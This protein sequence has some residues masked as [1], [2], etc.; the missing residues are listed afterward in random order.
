MLMMSPRSV[1]LLLCAESAD[2]YRSNERQCFTTGVDAMERLTCLLAL[3]LLL[4]LSG[5]ADGQTFQFTVAGDVQNP[6]TWV[7]TEI[8]HGD[9]VYLRDVLEKAGAMGDG[10]AVIL[11]GSSLQNGVT[12]FVS[13]Q[14]AGRGSQLQNGDIVVFHQTVTTQSGKNNILLIAHSIPHVVLLDEVGN[15]MRDLLAFLHLPFP[16]QQTVPVMR[17][18]KGGPALRQIP[19]NGPLVHGD[20]VLLNSITSVDPAQISQFFGQMSPEFPVTPSPSFIHTVANQRTIE[21]A[22]D[23][24]GHGGHMLPSVNADSVS[25]DC[26][27]GNLRFPVIAAA[28][29]PVIPGAVAEPSVAAPSVILDNEPVTVGATIAEGTSSLLW[30]LVF[31]FGLLGA[32]TLLVTGWLR[33]RRESLTL[34]EQTAASQ[35]TE[36]VAGEVP[37]Y[38]TS[39]GQTPILNEQIQSASFLSEVS[40]TAEV[41]LPAVLPTD[42]ATSIEQSALM[43]DSCQA[44]KS[45]QFIDEQEWFG[46]NW[47][48]NSLM[49][50]VPMAPFGTTESAAETKL[51]SKM[52]DIGKS[53]NEHTP[54]PPTESVP[55]DQVS[56]VETSDALEDLI[57]NRLPLEVKQA[58]LPL[59]VTLFGRPAGPRRLRIDAAHT[60]VAPP[61]FA[62]DS[63]SDQTSSQKSTTTATVR[64]QDASETASLDRALNYLHQRGHE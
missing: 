34:K 10:S 64:Q 49:N 45:N 40:I 17:T 9:S 19:P 3:T 8:A 55:V 41:P 61:N 31:I 46:G 44:S 63:R 4:I 5:T 57:Q 15:Q 11:R 29:E 24:T 52:A 60:Q 2:R 7:D 14:M 51:V 30:N 25:D 23:S 53:K 6:N 28:V 27:T 16:L 1:T 56:P 21:A 38:A 36:R 37:V 48:A 20:V 59:R 22:A 54:E 32:V 62:M 58:E 35:Y 33:T 47:Q 50:A 18:Y 12:E 42:T 13:A 43:S 26:E 39:V